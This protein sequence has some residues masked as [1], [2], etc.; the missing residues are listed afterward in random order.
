MSIITGF[1]KDG[2]IR[3]LSSPPSEN[4]RWYV[5]SP[6]WI[7]YNCS[8]IL[9]EFC[10][11]FLYLL[12]PPKCKTPI[13]LMEPLPFHLDIRLHTK[14][15]YDWDSLG[16]VTIK[17]LQAFTKWPLGKHNYYDTLLESIWWVFSDES[18]GSSILWIFKGLQKCHGAFWISW[19]IQRS[20]CEDDMR[21][22]ES[23]S[24]S[25][26]VKY[27]ILIQQAYDYIINLD[28][29]QLQL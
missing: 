21:E 9:N 1:T 20:L 4:N 12:F 27:L 6:S 16:A 25:V 28:F 10:D 15:Y 17:H 2:R 23:K 13:T 18:L 8:L 24:A 14:L 7:R 26:V 11:F 3:P 22:K 29:D 5:C 19:V